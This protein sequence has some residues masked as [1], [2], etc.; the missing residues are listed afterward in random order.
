MRE[1]HGVRLAS[2][3]RRAAAFLIDLAIGD[4]IFMIVA[5]AVVWATSDGGG[6]FQ[7]TTPE[8]RAHQ[9]DMTRVEL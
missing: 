2:F 3:G 4:V 1:L 8:T 6:R 7:V 9:T 5:I